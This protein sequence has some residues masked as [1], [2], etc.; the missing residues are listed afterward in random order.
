MFIY[1]YMYINMYIINSQICFMLQL[2]ILIF[3]LI[4]FNLSAEDVKVLNIFTSV[5]EKILLSRWQ[6]LVV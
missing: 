1:I 3:N 2:F 4:G 5:V 6:L